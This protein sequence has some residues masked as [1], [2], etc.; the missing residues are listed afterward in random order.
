[1]TVILPNMLACFDKKASMRSLKICEVFE[2]SNRFS[3]YS[4]CFEVHQITIFNIFSNQT[5]FQAFWNSFEKLLFSIS[6]NLKALN[7]YLETFFFRS[8]NRHKKDEKD[9]LKLR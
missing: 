2:N 8:T 1:M 3:H 9:Y 7:F 5:F 6:K 4:G